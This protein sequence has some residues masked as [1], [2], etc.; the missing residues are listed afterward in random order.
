MRLLGL[1]VFAALF[2][3]SPATG[4]PIVIEFEGVAPSGS[5]TVE[6]NATR[7]EDGFSMFIDHGHYRDSAAMSPSRPSNGTD[8]LMN[9]NSLGV[10]FTFPG[11]GT[12]SALS[13]DASEWSSAAGGQNDLQAIGSVF[14]GGT[15]TQT[16]ITDATFGFQTFVLDPSFTN[17]VRFRLIDTSGEMAWDNVAFAATAVPEPASLVLLGTGLTGVAMNAMR[18]RKQ[19]R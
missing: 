9:D 16:F 10:L 7:F 1:V 18:R 2:A 4:A 8:Y 17:L 15:V 3:V 19:P 6:D 12:F 5:D 13:F 11:L 14:G